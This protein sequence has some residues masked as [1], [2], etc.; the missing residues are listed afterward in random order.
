MY[1]RIPVLLLFFFS[2]ISA[3]IRST[4]R[5]ATSTNDKPYCSPKSE[6]TCDKG[7]THCG[8]WV[9]RTFH[10]NNCIVREIT[11]EQARE[12]IGSRTLAFVGDSQIRDIATG[13]SLF[14]MDQTPESATAEKF[15]KVSAEL[16]NTATKI[17]HYKDWAVNVGDH[18][19]GFF[20]PSKKTAEEKG[21]KWQIQAW[22]LYSHDELLPGDDDKPNNPLMVLANQLV[23]LPENPELR[24]VDMGFWCHGLHDSGWWDTPPYGK[25]YYESIVKHW[26]NI[27]NMTGNT[28]KAVQS[29]KG[30]KEGKVV[31]SVFVS[32]NP[33]CRE[34]I[35]A[36]FVSRERL[37]IQYAMVEE[38]VPYMNKIMRNRQLPY[39][40]AAS[41]LRT[42]DRCSLTPDGVHVAGWVNVFRAKM[43]LGMLCDEKNQWREDAYVYFK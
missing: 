24:Y 37:N 30:S 10:P 43:L 42:D 36:G 34:K 9:G 27:Y 40:D 26:E 3:S 5:S 20:Y 7:D 16:G 38:T 32:M 4:S 6:K 33:E 39:W 17:N 8:K 41:V 11:A 22:M 1:T 19:N 13:L 35:E 12:C 28:I 2:S 29:V 18:N 14:L 25:H 21:W 15:D 31:P 23:G